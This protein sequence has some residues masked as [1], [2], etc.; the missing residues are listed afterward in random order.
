MSSNS[1]TLT[2]DGNTN[3]LDQ[4][5]ESFM[6]FRAIFE[7]LYFGSDSKCP[8]NRVYLMC[9]T[10]DKPPVEKKAIAEIKAEAEIE[11]GRQFKMNPARA[12]VIKN[13]P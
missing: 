11:D 4:D 8:V 5:F 13:V 3:E 7:H 1:S 2:A 6:T 9:L 10:C 12:S